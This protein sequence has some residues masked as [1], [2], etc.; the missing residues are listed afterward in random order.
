MFDA[1]VVRVV[2]MSP[3][4]MSSST[5]VTVTVWGVLQLVLEK[6]RVSVLKEFSVASFPVVAT[7]TFEVGSAS[8]T[9]VYVEEAPPSVVRRSPDPSVVP[10]L[11]M[12]TPL[13]SSSVFL[14]VVVADSL[15]A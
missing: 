1:V 8:R 14:T 15:P 10:V 13:V 2:V 4:T 11:V 9:T 3:S 12:V 6:L 5:P 7:V